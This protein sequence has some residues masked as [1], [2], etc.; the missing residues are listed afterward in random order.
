MV[1][2]ATLFEESDLETELKLTGWTMPALWPAATPGPDI[3]PPLFRCSSCGAGA[4]W[5]EKTGRVWGMR[6]MV[7]VPPP[8]P[9]DRIVIIETCES[10]PV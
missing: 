8:R 9:D 3:P 7:C 1:H 4:W 5:H 6:C 10:E 2:Q